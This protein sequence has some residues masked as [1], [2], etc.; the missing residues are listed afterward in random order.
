ML[1]QKVSNRELLL[2]IDA[3]FTTKDAGY[4]P[5]YVIA[6]AW[7]DRQ[8]K[9]LEHQTSLIFAEA[10]RLGIALVGVDPSTRYNEAPTMWYLFNRNMLASN[11]RLRQLWGKCCGPRLP[12]CSTPINC[13]ACCDLSAL[14]NTE[15]LTGCTLLTD[16]AVFT[17]FVPGRCQRS[18]PASTGGVTK[19]Q[20]ALAATGSADATTT[21]CATNQ[22]N[23]SASTT[24][25]DAAARLASQNCQY[26]TITK[27]NTAGTGVSCTSVTAPSSASVAAGAATCS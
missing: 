22:T 2:A 21:T 19:E 8:R 9:S 26:D 4:K 14:G 25:C 23:G 5:V 16:N 6:E 3:L 17:P 7:T 12:A 15:V 11:A 1:S 13:N 10:G 27:E 24:L 18:Q 20:R